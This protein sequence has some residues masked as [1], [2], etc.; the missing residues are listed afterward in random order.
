MSW[1][2]LRAE[3]A[4]C[5]PPQDQ[6]VQ[7]L[8]WSMASLILYLLICITS[9][10][11]ILYAYYV[12]A[13]VVYLCMWYMCV[14]DA[15][16]RGVYMCGICILCVYVVYMSVCLWYMCIHMGVWW[17]HVYMPYY[18][19]YVCMCSQVHRWIEYRSML[20]VFLNCSPPY[21]MRQGLS[22]PEAHWL[23][24]LGTP[25]IRPTPPTA[26]VSLLLELQAWPQ[27]LSFHGSAGDWTQVVMLA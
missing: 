3:T 13:N 2:T 22:E 6:W 19:Q 1:P 7:A 11:F 21:F 25:E 27:H 26:S 18:E 5:P 10:L 15:Y 12:C 9:Y 16:M 4:I 17:M 23:T 14:Y 24:R 20:G 8:A